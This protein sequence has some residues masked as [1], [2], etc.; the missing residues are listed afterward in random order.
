[1]T[2]AKDQEVFTDEELKK[3]AAAGKDNGNISRTDALLA[4]LILEI[5]ETRKSSVFNAMIGT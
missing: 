5:R 3:I 4:Q 1:M 2:M